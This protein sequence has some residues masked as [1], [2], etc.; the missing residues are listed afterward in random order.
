MSGKSRKDKAIFV[1]LMSIFFI[2]ALWLAL[3]LQSPN[4]AADSNTTVITHLNVTNTAPTL[5]SV[6]VN[7]GSIDLNP[8][9]VTVVNCTGLIYDSNGWADIRRVNATLYDTAFGDGLVYDNNYRYFNS[10]CNTSCV[11]YE[12]SGTNA[13]CTCRFNVQY[14]A[15]NGSWQCNMTVG[16]LYGLADNENS[17]NITI[18]QIMAINTPTE[19]DYGNLSVTQTSS[20][21]MVNLTNYGNTR[22]NISVVGYGGTNDT[23]PWAGN[24][25]FIC[26]YG[27]ISISN[28][29]Y[30]WNAS[31]SYSAMTNLTNVTTAIDRFYLPVRVNDATYQSDRNST[32]WKVYIPSDISG[33]CNGTVIFNA[34]PL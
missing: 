21:V 27:N 31:Q 23:V 32:Y 17:T 13:S 5:Y 8:G 19:I 11:S 26:A 3:T 1:V 25:S 10:S 4:V 18:N 9:N 16:D 22:V 24:Y 7:P 6:S 14:Y 34:D 29:R 30:S 20:A 15:N 28:E 12:G 33:Y 2:M